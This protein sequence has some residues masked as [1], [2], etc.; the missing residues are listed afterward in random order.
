MTHGTGSRSTFEFPC[1]VN[2]FRSQFALYLA[3]WSGLAGATR[4]TRSDFMLYAFTKGAE[5]RD[6]RVYGLV[7]LERFAFKF[8]FLDPQLKTEKLSKL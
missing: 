5:V 1:R 7:M 4:L 3:L 8:L 2:V 6:G